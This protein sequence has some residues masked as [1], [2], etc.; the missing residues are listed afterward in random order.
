MTPG[1][2]FGL[3]ATGVAGNGTASFRPAD[4]TLDYQLTAPPAPTIDGAFADWAGHPYGQNP[5]GS[6]VNPSGNLVYDANVDLLATAVDVQANFTGYAQVAGIMLGGEDIPVNVLRPGPPAPPVNPPPPS[7]PYVPETGIDVVY[8]YIDADNSSATGILSRVGN[9]TYGFDYAIAV[10]GRNG[11]VNSS[12]LYQ[13]SAN[14]T[15]QRLGPAAAA[16]DSHRLEFAV[17]ASLVNLR[18]GYQVV[19]YASDWELQY[20]VALP[21]ENVASFTLGTFVKPPKPPPKNPPVISIVK[22]V[23]A[24]TAVP[25]QTLTYLIYFNNTGGPA[26]TVWVNDTLPVGVTYVSASTAPTTTGPTYG[27]VFTNLGPGSHNTLQIVARVNGNGTDGSSQVNNAN[28]AYTDAHGDVAG[29]GSS[30][31]SFTY[32]RPSITVQKTVSPADAVPGQTVTYTIHYNNT[33]SAA[34]NVSI[35]DTMP[36][37]LVNIAS[38]PSPT[39]VVGQTYYWNVTNVAPRS[40]NSVTITAQVSS[41][42][43]G[44]QLVNWA[45]LNYTSTYGFQFPGSQSSAVVAIP[46][47]SDFLFVVA[48]PALILGMRWRSRRSK[49]EEKKGMSG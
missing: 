6:V 9:R 4:T 1:L 31:A 15:W 26:K 35:A 42:F 48:V 40:S 43:N 7:P 25:G 8:A 36:S 18:V 23:S 27:W 5:V 11:L 2:T 14:G 17:N 38:N 12:A 45:F 20:D 46:E 32:R 22:R 3:Q 13:A 28:V 47:L 30:S 44:T 39:R 16:L 34:A 33:G 41:A 29:R 49:G 37:G 10:Q 19:Y 24:S 21:S